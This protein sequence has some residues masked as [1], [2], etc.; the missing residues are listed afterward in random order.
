MVKYVALLIVCQFLTPSLYGQHS[1]FSLDSLMHNCQRYN[2]PTEFIYTHFDKTVYTNN[3]DVWFT[4]YLFNPDTIKSIYHTLSVL[5]VS[6]DDHSIKLEKLFSI[7]DLI[8][9]GHLVIP[10]SLYPGA[11]HFLVYHN[12]PKYVKGVAKVFSQGITVKTTLKP[13]PQS[14]LTISEPVMPALSETKLILKVNWGLKNPGLSRVN[15]YNGRNIVKT[16]TDKEGNLVLFLS[17]KEVD[18]LNGYFKLSASIGKNVQHI[19]IKLP[20]KKMIPL[21]HFFPEGGNLVEGTENYIGCEILSTEGMPIAAKGILFSNDTPIDT[22]QTS[23]T[24]IAKFRLT[25]KKGSRYYFRI[26]DGN[27]L[28]NEQ[29][30]L[31]EIKAY[32]TPIIHLPSSIVNDTLLVYL[33]AG[34]PT[35]VTIVVHQDNEVIAYSQLAAEA[36]KKKI[37]ISLSEAKKGLAYVT[38]FGENGRPVS[39]RIFFAHYDQGPVINISSDKRIYKTRSNVIVSL[40]LNGVSGI[41]ESVASIACVQNNR[42]ETLN[43][44]DIETYS[45]LK[46]NLGSIPI[47]PIGEY[48]KNRIYME[49]LLLVKGWRNY[50][51]ADSSKSSNRTNSHPIMLRFIGKVLQNKKKLKEPV[52]LIIAGDSIIRSISTDKDGNFELSKSLIITRDDKKLLMMVASKDPSGYMVSMHNPYQDINN[53]L[54]EQFVSDKNNLTQISSPSSVTLEG[55]EK[56]TELNEV[57]I[58]GRVDESIY[59]KKNFASLID[60]QDFVCQYGVVNC[61]NHKN[62]SGNL[63]PRLG[64]MYKMIVNG[65]FTEVVYHGCIDAGPKKIEKFKLML[66]GIQS[67]VEFYPLDSTV[68][69]SS[70]PNYLSTIYWNH[71]MKLTSGKYFKL[72]FMTADITGDYRIVIQGMSGQTPFYGECTFQVQSK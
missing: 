52:S 5:L 50:I 68:I 32:T 11:Y 14:S 21:V 38:L 30:P 37:K 51:Q 23:F 19:G 6:D 25:P 7:D 47:D 63:T 41:S 8:S 28:Q 69:N 18:D 4:S 9:H 61:P 16:Q 57:K 33:S 54:S 44:N 67:P 48:F 12:Y 55:M 60:C 46:Q 66:E 24:G 3:E 64:T 45:Y 36:T 15:Y 62:G 42:I 13:N 22:I 65:K 39:E 72:S 40:N 56:T 59:S 43:K 2:S 71:K 10:D 31:P 17:E 27:G 53:D 1:K 58:I 70:E 49:D 29:F 34:S 20:I 35:A 26:V